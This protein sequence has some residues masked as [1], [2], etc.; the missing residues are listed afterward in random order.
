MNADES[1]LVYEGVSYGGGIRGH[2][3]VLVV[4]LSHFGACSRQ[5]ALV[6]V[7]VCS[8]VPRVLREHA[9]CGRGSSGRIH[10]GFD[11]LLLVDAVPSGGATTPMGVTVV[12]VLGAHFSPHRRRGGLW[13]VTVVPISWVSLMRVEVVLLVVGLQ[14]PWVLA[15]GDLLLRGMPLLLAEPGHAPWLAPSPSLRTVVRWG[16]YVGT[17]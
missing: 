17:R 11:V 15:P 16:S 5:Q 6:H 2:D 4:V 3:V 10:G 1:V 8:V 13:H 12:G 14:S 7:V 9:C